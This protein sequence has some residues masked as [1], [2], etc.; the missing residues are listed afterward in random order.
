MSILGGDDGERLRRDAERVRDLEEGYRYEPRSTSGGRPIG[1]DDG[2]GWRDLLDR[3][4]RL[5]HAAYLV[6]RDVHFALYWVAL[7]GP[8]KRAPLATAEAQR[9]HDRTAW[10]D[11]VLDVSA[12]DLRR[13]VRFVTP[14]TVLVSLII[15]VGNVPEEYLASLAVVLVLV[16]LLVAI[17][18]QVTVFARQVRTRLDVAAWRTD[19]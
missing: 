10:E 6:F 11:V 18:V 12:R 2:P 1:Q 7:A 19:A 8:A 5:L 13:L 15:L 9:G 17:G 16:V 14:I 4:L 3:L